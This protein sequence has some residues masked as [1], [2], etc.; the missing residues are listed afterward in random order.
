MGLKQTEMASSVFEDPQV[1]ERWSRL[2]EWLD[3]YGAYWREEGLGLVTHVE[4]L[5]S[6]ALRAAERGCLDRGE[7]ARGVCE[8]VRALLLS[9]GIEPGVVEGY[10]LKGVRKEVAEV[11]AA[12]FPRLQSPSAN[13]RK[14]GSAATAVI[15]V[16]RAP[17]DTCPE[18]G[19]KLVFLKTLKRY[20]CFTC[21]KY[22]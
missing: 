1:S 14:V 9:H 17:G 13:S 16:E 8:R 4:L 18:C 21:K 3:R 12:V 19:S 22:R 20:Y 6:A 5:V 10:E 2:V 7:V 11:V 15:D